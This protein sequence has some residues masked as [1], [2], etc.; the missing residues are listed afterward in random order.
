MR[1]YTPLR[2]S[3]IAV[4]FAGAVGCADRFS[5]PSEPVSMPKAKKPKAGATDPKAPAGPTEPDTCRYNFDGN[6]L[7]TPYDKKKHLKAKSTS[8]EAD[9]QLSGAETATWQARRTQVIGAIGTLSDALAIDP[10]SPHATY[11]MAAAYALVG[12]KKCMIAMLTR[13]SDLAA[14]PEIATDVGNLK[15]KVKTDSSF[16]ALRKDAEGAVQ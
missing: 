5:G 15:K 16:D 8:Q 10:Y 14:I 13:L 2:L 9:N 3:L 12:K 4:L 1:A 6:A 7:A 11:G